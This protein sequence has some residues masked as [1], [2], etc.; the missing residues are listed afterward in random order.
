[1]FRINNQGV[2]STDTELWS[3]GTGNPT[4]QE[5][6]TLSNIGRFEIYKVGD[7]NEFDCQDED[8]LFGSDSHPLFKDCT[9][10][11]GTCPQCS[12][13][14]ECMSGHCISIGAGQGSVCGNREGKI[15]GGG[16]CNAESDCQSGE[17]RGGVGKPQVQD[18]PQLPKQVQCLPGLRDRCRLPIRTVFAPGQWKESLRQL[19]WDH[20][21]WR[22]LPQ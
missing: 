15:S 19:P 14:S 11:C 1:M 9:G 16:C 13:D 21:R 3:T 20:R 22:V 12:F 4:T 17:M 7:Q 8:L 18:D 10:S 5:F 2:L 6:A